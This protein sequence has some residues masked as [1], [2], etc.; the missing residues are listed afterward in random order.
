[1]PAAGRP[2]GSPAERARRAWGR[3][4]LDNAAMEQ[5]ATQPPSGEPR[6][7]VLIAE[8]DADIRQLLVVHVRR[9]GCD[10]IEVADGQAALDAMRERTPDLLLLDVQ[11]PRV[12]GVEVT[13]QVRAD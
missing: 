12:S 9:E 11:M 5:E 6:P 3:G 8:D 13:R 10:A 4:R 1:M 7:L 2:P